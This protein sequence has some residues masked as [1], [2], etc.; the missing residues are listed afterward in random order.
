MSF[1]RPKKSR[2]IP[3]A[4]HAGIIRFSHLPEPT[5][6]GMNRSLH[7]PVRRRRNVKSINR[8]SPLGV[9]GWFVTEF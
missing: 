2:K 3:A 8:E 9:K 7:F 6:W 1:R 4:A 5:I